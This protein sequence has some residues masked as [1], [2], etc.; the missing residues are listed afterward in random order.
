MKLGAIHRPAPLAVR[1]LNRR[2]S[3]HLMSPPPA[4]DWHQKAPADGNQLANDRY[5]CCVEVADYQLIRLH[6]A[7]AFGDQWK[8]TVPMVL[9]RYSMLTGFNA[10]TGQPDAG[11]DTVSD[12]TNWCSR[13]IRLDS[14]NLDVPLWS[15]VDS[16]DIN[17]VNLSIALCGGV[18]ITILLPLAAQDL[19]VWSKAP[20]TGPSWRPGSWGGHRVLSG[21]YDGPNRTVRTW[22]RDIDMHPA[23]W[24]A[25]VVAVDV[26]LSRQWFS[27]TGLSP[28]NLDWDALQGD[29]AFL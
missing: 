3:L 8:P 26:L 19:S 10:I 23:F 18:L 28:S 1:P 9:T 25:Y 21:K 17:E 24:D 14:Q 11:T 5:G 20:G 29:M 16:H 7:N 13:G 2:A 4:A 22:G 27:A 15:I 6:R 12:L